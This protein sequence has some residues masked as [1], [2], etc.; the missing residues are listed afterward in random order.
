MLPNNTTASHFLDFLVGVTLSPVTWQAF[1]IIEL[2]STQ[3]TLE[4]SARHPTPSHLQTLPP[5]AC[6]ALRR[7]NIHHPET[8]NMEMNILYKAHLVS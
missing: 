7:V 3:L 1:Q 4:T 5:L 8:F 2:L 6:L